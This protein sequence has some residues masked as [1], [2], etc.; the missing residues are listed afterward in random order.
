M[1]YYALQNIQVKQNILDDDKY[2]HLFT[3]ERV[4]EL[5]KNGSSFRQ[6][7][8]EVGEEVEKGNVLR[9]QNVDYSHQGSIGNLCND[10]IR[11]KMEKVIQAFDFEKANKALLNL[12]NKT[13][14]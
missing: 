8:K 10:K 6:A 2:V 9:P 14:S 11:Q 1:L 4:N 7:Y 12:L 13:N 5:V 3:V